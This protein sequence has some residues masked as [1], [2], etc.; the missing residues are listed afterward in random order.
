LKKVNRMPNIRLLCALTVLFAVFAAYNTQ[1]IGTSDNNG[2]ITFTCASGGSCTTDTSSCWDVDEIN[3]DL[4]CNGVAV[5]CC[6]SSS[7]VTKK[8]SEVTKESSECMGISDDNGVITF[9][10]S[11]G[12]SCTVDAGSC[13]DIDDINGQ[14][15]CDGVA[16]SCCCSSSE[17]TKKSSEVTKKSS[18]VNKKS[19]KIPKK[20][21]EVTKKSSEFSE[22]IQTE[23]CQ[24]PPSTFTQNGSSSGWVGSYSMSDITGDYW[25]CD[26][27]D[28][29]CPDA[30]CIVLITS[31]GYNTYSV[32]WT[33]YETFVSQEDEYIDSAS[34]TQ[35][36]WYA[37]ALLCTYYDTTAGQTLSAGLFADQDGESG[38]SIMEFLVTSDTS[39]INSETTLAKWSFFETTSVTHDSE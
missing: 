2:V 33:V 34:C 36:D 17:V 32:S 31:T 3:G 20:S 37:N 39:D 29:D 11:S 27:S 19:F 26:K 38:S 6:C 14:M 5:P 25:D 10:C 23:G 16:V 30:G 28:Y 18:E 22:K 21:S 4:Y 24:S 7:E 35:V 15:Y 12:G 8:S 9:T 13:N 1:C